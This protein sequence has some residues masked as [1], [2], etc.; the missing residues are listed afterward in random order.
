[1]GKAHYAEV[2][3]ADPRQMRREEQEA[4]RRLASMLRA[5][6]AAGPG[7]AAASEAIAA[8][9]AVWSAL[10]GDLVKPDNAL[11]GPLRAKIISI[12]IFLLKEAEEI[13]C[14]RSINFRGLREIVL[15]ISEGLS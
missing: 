10:L 6:E 5:A 2:V 14:G 4:L 3:A 7:S 12:G 9:N 15:T 13:R 8:V 1:M 11:P